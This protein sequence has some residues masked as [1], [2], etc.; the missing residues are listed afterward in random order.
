MSETNRATRRE[1][2]SL[3][4]MLFAMMAPFSYMT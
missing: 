1:I 3:H 4:C 2:A